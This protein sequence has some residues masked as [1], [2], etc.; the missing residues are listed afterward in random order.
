MAELEQII[1]LINAGQETVAKKL[2]TEMI[3]ENPNDDRVWFWLSTVVSTDRQRYCLE[4]AVSL[5]PDNQDASYALAQLNSSENE[6]PGPEADVIA[7]SSEIIEHHNME[8]DPV[9]ESE[10]LNGRDLLEDESV[11]TLDD[12]FS[13]AGEQEVNGLTDEDY[14]G[15]STEAA[16][17][18]E[19]A[20]TD[21]E[22]PTYEE[23]IINEAASNDMGTA[24]DEKI[25]TSDQFTIDDIE[26]DIAAFGLGV[27]TFSDATAVGDEAADQYIQPDVGESEASKIIPQD[28]NL[29][30]QEG[31]VPSGTQAA[32]SLPTLP[33]Y[34]VK[35]AG[36]VLTVTLLTEERI[37][38]AHG[39][40]G[41][42]EE[43]ENSLNGGVF[44]K[45]AL[46]ITGAVPLS[47]ISEVNLRKNLLQVAYTKG[48][49]NRS[50]DFE[51]SNKDQAR[52]ALDEMGA[53]L[54]PD[55]EKFTQSKHSCFG[56]VAL[57]L[58]LIFLGV[59]TTILALGVRDAGGAGLVSGIPLVGQA[60]NLCC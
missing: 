47:S 60:F 25:D 20:W 37:V 28:G 1:E 4:R 38:S 56:I 6:M 7:E 16:D 43:I 34:W 8:D 57:V 48:K 24:A 13:D 30:D 5:N 35:T 3:K 52:D 50:V 39:N 14:Q 44:P 10:S 17:P 27:A 49:S 9:V 18:L 53:V 23:F 31:S 42:F 45:G 32:S 40:S 58:I 36:D 59:L 19:S 33:L 15:I 26:A 22:L 12:I 21:N 46:K 55:F 2:L 54:E 11:P 41:Q 51:F 29:T